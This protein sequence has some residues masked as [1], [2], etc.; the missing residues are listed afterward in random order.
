MK[1]RQVFEKEKD[2]KIDDKMSSC[3]ENKVL[4]KT[5]YVTPLNNYHQ[6]P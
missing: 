6:S 3:K 1:K 5:G 2:Y 4:K